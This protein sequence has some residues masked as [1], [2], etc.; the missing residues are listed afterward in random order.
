MKLVEL[1]KDGHSTYV[2]K[3]QIGFM[4]QEGWNFPSVKVFYSTKHKG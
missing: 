4:M 1:R 2:K 3:S